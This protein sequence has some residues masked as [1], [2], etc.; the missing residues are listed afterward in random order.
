MDQLILL[1][2][3]DEPVRP[4]TA[5]GRPKPAARSR[6]AVVPE[7]IVFT[8][9]TFLLAIS[10]FVP[11]QV[12]YT[13][14]SLK[15]TATFTVS[16]FLFPLILLGGK[17]R[18][19]WPDA[20]VLLLYT[21]YFISI[22]RGESLARAVETNGRIVLG[23]GTPYLVGRY[24]AQ[25]A[26]RMTRL[27]KLVVTGIAIFA[28]LAI[29][30][31]VNRFNI[32]SEFWG[33]PYE[34][35]KEQRLGFTR[36]HGFTIH[37]IMFGLVCGIFVPLAVVAWKE[38]RRV[39]G[40][41]PLVKAGCLMLGAVLSFST[42]AWLPVVISLSMVVWDYYAPIPTRRRWPWT[43]AVCISG[44]FIL[45]Y[46]SGRPLLRILM[47]KF[48]L[49][50]AEAWYYRWRLYERVFAV[51]DARHF[52]FGY[53]E[54]TP[55][56]AMSTGWSID[57]NFLVVYLKHG[58]V[59]L[60]LWVGLTLAVF[61]YGGKAVWAGRDTPA[62]RMTRA[63]M[64]GVVGVCM[65]QFSVALFSVASTLYWLVLGLGVG[66]AQVCRREDTALSRTERKRQPKGR[67]RP[68]SCAAAAAAS[69]PGLPR[70]RV[71]AVWSK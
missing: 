14:G 40:R 66:L 18:W 8:L 46:A 10:F 34:P 48:H 32:H 52:W 47:M 6:R 57:N 13:V 41:W 45:E 33:Y 24:I 60:V 51:M 3:V 58:F 68:G 11:E 1:D 64:F 42:G 36:A 54:Q 22:A 4:R 30:E 53:G 23:T 25:D 61:F 31:A 9:L 63:L 50:S 43:F 29:F 16:I 38:K 28:V 27:L 37:A 44:Y 21:A 7:S 20:V 5:A 15:F 12:F 67:P 56:D 2:K 59:G 26:V 39:V 19:A 17:I 70:P 62:T 65:T 49:S 35:H 71:P 69:G 55:F